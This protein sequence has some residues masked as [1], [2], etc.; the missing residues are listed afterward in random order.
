[1]AL[2]LKD[3]FLGQLKMQLRGVG[4]QRGRLRGDRWSFFC[5]ADDTRA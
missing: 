4:A 5:R 3:P 2:V 1:M